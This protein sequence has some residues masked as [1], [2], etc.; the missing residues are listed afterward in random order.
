RLELA[1]G[2]DMRLA[3]DHAKMG[4]TET[5]LAIIPGAGGTQRLPRLIGMGKAKRMILSAKAI[6]ASEALDIGL[7]E[8]IASSDELMATGLKWARTIAANGPIALRQAKMAMNHGVNM[9]MDN[10]LMF[11]RQCYK[12]TIPTEDRIEGLVAFR[13]KRKPVYKGK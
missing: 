3:V 6:S 13:E 1:L 12:D 10:A 4:L 7:I 8:D 5:S 9:S 11:E 2:C